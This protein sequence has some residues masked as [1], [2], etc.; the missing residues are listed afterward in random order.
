MTTT[1]PILCSPVEVVFQLRTSTPAEVCYGCDD[2]SMFI[3]VDKFA[4]PPP[5]LLY[6]RLWSFKEHSTGNSR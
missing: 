6:A 2:L 5:Q 3:P 1:D 4:G